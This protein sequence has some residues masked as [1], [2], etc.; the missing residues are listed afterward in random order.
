MAATGHVDFQ[1]AHFYGQ[2]LIGRS[3]FYS[4]RT[5]VGREAKV[6]SWCCV[7]SF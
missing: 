4:L 1:D 6:G 2:S 5:F 3:T 7:G